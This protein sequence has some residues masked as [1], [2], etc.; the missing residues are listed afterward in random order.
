[1]VAIV[2]AVLARVMGA[3]SDGGA[4]AGIVI[5]FLLMFAAGLGGFLP[6]LT[7]LVLTLL[8]TRWRSERKRGLGVA[9]RGGGRTASPG[10]RQPWCGG[11]LRSGGGS[12]FRDIPAF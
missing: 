1:M 12:S 10:G 6:L 5:A 4:L 7:V 11:A 8:A 3:V 9:E 2:F